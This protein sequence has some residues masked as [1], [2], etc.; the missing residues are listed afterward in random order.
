MWHQYRRVCATGLFY[1]QE[2]V[3]AESHHSLIAIM[4]GRLKMGV[5]ESIDAYLDLAKDVFQEKGIKTK[6]FKW[7]GPMLGMPRFRGDTLADA[8]KHIVAK[9][10]G[11]TETLMFDKN[12]NACKV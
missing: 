10:T 3:H 5:Q 12:E 7:V 6:Y 4:L 1:F 2:M 9:K 8:V 11:S